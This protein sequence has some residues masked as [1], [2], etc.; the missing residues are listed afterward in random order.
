MHLGGP[1]NVQTSRVACVVVLFF[2]NISYLYWILTPFSNVRKLRARL[3]FQL[4]AVRPPPSF[5]KVQMIWSQGRRVLFQNTC[6]SLLK[7]RDHQPTGRH[8]LGPDFVV[9]GGW[10]GGGVRGVYF[11]ICLNFPFRCNCLFSLA[12]GH[13]Y[14]L[15]AY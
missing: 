12:F 7:K 3:V 1:K 4:F 14:R 9:V 10:S 11:Q 6:K 13:K 2:L 15:W 8:C 5:Q